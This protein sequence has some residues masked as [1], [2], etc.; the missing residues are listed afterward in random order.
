MHIPIVAMLSW[1]PLLGQYAILQA[2]CKESWLDQN[3][4][5]S[6]DKGDVSTHFV[7]NMSIA[8]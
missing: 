4:P 8:K 7:C 5:L 3:S 6:F 2:W 1:N